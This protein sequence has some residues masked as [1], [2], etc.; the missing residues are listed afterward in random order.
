MPLPLGNGSIFICTNRP[1]VA[2]ECVLTSIATDNVTDCFLLLDRK[3]EED[4][5]DLDWADIVKSG[6]CVVQS[7]YNGLSALRNI[8]ITIANSSWILFVDDDIK[9]MAG[10]M[11]RLKLALADGHPIVGGKLIYGEYA[12]KCPCWITRNQFHYL[13]VHA[14]NTHGR[15]WGAFMAFDL[16]FLH[17]ES[18]IFDESLDRKGWSLLSGGDTS[19]VQKCLSVGGRPDFIS[20]AVAEHHVRKYR[21]G[22]RMIIRRVWMQ[23][24]TEVVRRSRGRGV[25][26]ELKRNLY[27]GHPVYL[28]LGVGY[29]LLFL[30]SV[31]VWTVRRR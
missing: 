8:A 4:C 2:L 25:I 13:G 11:E 17:R 7:I 27:C 5:D 30:L 26:K 16:D 15:I 12:G 31:A 21:I 10:S 22:F 19:F 3:L 6:V 9:L 20:C 1:R 14:P 28:L 29:F 24:Y 23:G 18:L